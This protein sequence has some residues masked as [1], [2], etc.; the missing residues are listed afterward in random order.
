VQN[1]GHCAENVHQYREKDKGK[2]FLPWAK[3]AKS[4]GN[5]MA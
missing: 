1:L 5:S 2:A 4:L 3:S